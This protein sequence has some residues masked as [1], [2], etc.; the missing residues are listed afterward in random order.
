[1]TSNPARTAH[2]DQLLHTHL[3]ALLGDVEPGVIRLLRQHLEW[4]EIAGGDT[5]M[6]QG[7]AGDS[8]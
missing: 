6:R 5:L 7:D 8:M 2:Q 1:M 3:V 4:V